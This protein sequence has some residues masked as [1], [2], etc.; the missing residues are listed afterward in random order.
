MTEYSKVNW[1]D[2]GVR[3][4][5]SGE[6]DLNTPQTPG[7]TRSAAITRASAG[8]SQLWTGTVTIHPDAKTGAHHHI[9][10]IPASSV[11][12]RLLLLGRS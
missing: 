5:R 4:V 9:P 3:V 12:T 2:H 7:M 11:W 8:A 1:R 6:L 10:S